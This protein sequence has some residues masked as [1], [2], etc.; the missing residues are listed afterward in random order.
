[1]SL[2][3]SSGSGV[4]GLGCSLSVKIPEA[5]KAPGSRATDVIQV[6]LPSVLVCLGGAVQGRCEGTSVH[7]PEGNGL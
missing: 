1:M 3:V 5:P 7:F 4:T 6:C 2:R